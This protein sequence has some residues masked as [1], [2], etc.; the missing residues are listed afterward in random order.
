M[1]NWTRFDRKA[2]PKVEEPLVTLQA[3]GTLSMNSAGYEAIGQ[4]G[5]VD[6]LY[7]EGAHLIGFEPAEKGSPTAYPIR[8][9]QNGKSYQTGGRGF[10]R[11]F[12][13]ELGEARRFSAHEAE[14]V[15]I[16]DLDSGGRP[17]GRIAR[18]RRAEDEQESK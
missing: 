2:R 10:C 7:D 17:V 4:P 13:I 18:E 14:G 1:P 9:Q 8:Q 16:V 5:Q 11:R 15:L 3:S 12:G 6:L